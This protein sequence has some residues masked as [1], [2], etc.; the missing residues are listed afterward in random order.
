MHDGG[1]TRV[2]VLQPQRHVQRDLQDAVQRQPGLA[3]LLLLL[4]LA[5]LLSW[6]LRSS[7]RGCAPRCWL[8]RGRVQQ[9]VQAGDAQLLHHAY[10]G[11]L[12]A[13]A[14]EAHHVVVP[15]AGQHRD[16]LQACERR[17]RVTSRTAPLGSV[18]CGGVP[19]YRP[20]M[21]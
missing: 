1:A 9:R 15:Q 13:A 11:G 8:R 2:Q 12:Q 4:C 7:G 18:G 20:I 5:V 6:A 19:T 10:V 14:D 17:G 21:R 16:L 3:L